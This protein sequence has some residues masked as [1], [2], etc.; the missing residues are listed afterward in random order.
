MKGNEFLDKM[1]LIDPRYVDAADAPSATGRRK[2][3]RWGVIAA[4]FCILI[5]AVTAMAM[6]DFGTQVIDFFASLSGSGPDSGESGYVLNIEI[7]KISADALEGAIREVPARIRQQFESY[8][9]FMS[10]SPD[11]WSKNFE[12]RNE[13]YDYIGFDGLKCLP[14]DW[15]ENRTIL[16]VRGTENGDILCASVET[17]YAVS[18]IQLQFLASIYTEKLE[19]SVTMHMVMLENADF[20]ESF[21]SSKNGKTLHV[22]ESTVLKSGYRTISGYLVENRVLYHLHI[23]CPEKDSGQ[24][25][26]L[27]RQWADL[28]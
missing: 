13:A 21:Y 9:P 3:I 5:S 24:A 12:S 26:E 8:Q 11:T 16:C 2:R 17:S 14:L 15:Q 27:L 10:W 19:G 25:K 28:V 6:S 4:C 7:E 1:E 22:L 23:S 20:E 18:D